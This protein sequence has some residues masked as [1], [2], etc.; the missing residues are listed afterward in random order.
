MKALAF[1][2]CGAGPALVLLHGLGS[3]KQAWAPVIPALAEHFDVL[4]IDLPGFGESPALPIGEQSLPATLAAG[5]AELLRSLGIAEAHIAGNSLGGWVALELAAMYPVASL[6]LLSPAGLWKK[7]TP[8]Y[9]RVSLRSSRW[10][11]QH[12]SRMLSRL[13]NHALGRVIVLGQTHGRPVHVD[14]ERG[15]AVISA[16]ATCVGFEATLKAT[17]PRR[18]LAG[19]PIDIP[20]TVAFGSRDWLLLPRQSRH[21][22]QLP[23]S[24]RVATLPRCGHVPMSD[25]PAA[26]AALIR[27]QLIGGSG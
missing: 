8:M 18:Y 2:R 3:S 25:D 27:S 22:D 6:T 9:C 15:R 24:T 1:T 16:M 5:V 12:T 26:V 19:P 13:V 20:V 7:T 4:A 11:A 23:P 21:L 17:S 10:L 14:P